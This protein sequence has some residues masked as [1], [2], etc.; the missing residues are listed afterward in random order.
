MRTTR[1]TPANQIVVVIMACL[2]AIFEE[3]ASLILTA[4]EEETG[5]RTIDRQC[6]ASSDALP[7]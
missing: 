7:I 3:M 1:K 4:A 6:M 5:M 2:W